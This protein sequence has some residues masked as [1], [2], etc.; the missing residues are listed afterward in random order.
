MPISHVENIDCMEA[1]KG[2]EDNAAYQR[3]RYSLK[4]DL[5]EFKKA[6]KEAAQR[7]YLRNIDKQKEKGKRY[8]ERNG[9]RI[10]QYNRI[11]RTKNPRG[12][13]DVIKQSAKRRNLACEIS[14]DE[15]SSWYDSQIRICFY[16]KR[17][18]ADIL[19]DRDVVQSI[20]KRLTVDRLDNNKGYALDNMALCCRRCN[21]IK[22][23]FFNAEEMIEIGKIIA[24]KYAGI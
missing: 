6:K 13:F 10:R 4:K 1:M 22:G 14:P 16:C 15:F 5:P 23:N 21:S 18:E 7:S 3:Y 12:I 24:K 2:F 11:Y 19:K 8:R 9:E 17:N 20:A